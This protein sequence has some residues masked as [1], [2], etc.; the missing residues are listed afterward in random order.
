MPKL[1]KKLDLNCS[2]FAKNLENIAVKNGEMEMRTLTFDA[3]VKLRAEFW[4]TKYK[5]TP[6]RPAP[7]NSN[8]SFKLLILMKRGLAANRT[9]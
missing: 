5:V 7:K 3:W 6:Q 9:R 4:K 2:S 8:S 1:K